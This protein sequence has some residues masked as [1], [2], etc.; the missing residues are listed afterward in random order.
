MRRAAVW[1]HL[2]DSIF[3]D[4]HEHGLDIDIFIASGAILKV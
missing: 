1:M 3:L 4:I 2:G